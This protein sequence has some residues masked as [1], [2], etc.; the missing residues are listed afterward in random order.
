[1]KVGMHYKLQ[2]LKIYNAQLL[3]KSAEIFYFLLEKWTPTS[4]NTTYIMGQ[5]EY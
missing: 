3:S 2:A 5:K 4:C 1:M